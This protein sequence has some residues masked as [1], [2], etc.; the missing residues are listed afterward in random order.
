MKCIL[1]CENPYAFGILAPIRNQLKERG[2]SYIWYID[3]DLFQ[4]FPES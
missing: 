4:G 2:D 3:K 1:F